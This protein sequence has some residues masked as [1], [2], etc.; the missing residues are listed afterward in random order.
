MPPE[1]GWLVKC[2]FIASYR[3][4]K[5]PLYDPTEHE[6]PAVPRQASIRGETTRFP[7]ARMKMSF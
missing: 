3:R 2:D 4:L 7:A 1:S 5:R 6:Q